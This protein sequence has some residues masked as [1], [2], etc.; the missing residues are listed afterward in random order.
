MT[1]D[2][3]RRV[4]VPPDISLLS[5]T[6]AILGWKKKEGCPSDNSRTSFGLTI[7]ISSTFQLIYKLL[8][9][10]LERGTY[11]ACSSAANR[12]ALSTISAGGRSDVVTIIYITLL[13]IFSSSY[14]LKLTT[15]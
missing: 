14:V 9:V 13:N 3:I 12:S 15:I 5:L 6:S 11:T 8:I 2:I 1:P 7:K 4:S 10:L